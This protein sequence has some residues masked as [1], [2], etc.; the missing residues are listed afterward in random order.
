MAFEALYNEGLLVE[1]LRH[2]VL[3]NCELGHAVKAFLLGYSEWQLTLALGALDVES[4]ARV[5]FT[6]LAGDQR[7]VVQGYSIVFVFVLFEN[8]SHLDK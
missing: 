7:A 5:P 3:A 1:E 8:R 4:E 2:G 6:H